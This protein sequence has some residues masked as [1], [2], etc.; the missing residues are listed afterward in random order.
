MGRIE[1]GF[2]VSDTFESCF[3]FSSEKPLATSIFDDGEMRA[4]IWEIYRNRLV[5]IFI[6]PSTLW[7]QYRDS[8]LKIF[9]KILNGIF[10]WA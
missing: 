2:G 5:Q 4:A 3:A 6:A 9:P 1:Q 7:N 10:F 8:N